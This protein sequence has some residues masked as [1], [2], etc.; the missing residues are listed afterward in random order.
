MYKGLRKNADKPDIQAFLWGRLA[1]F[2]VAE[3]VDLAGAV[4][5][6]SGQGFAI[7]QREKVAVENR[8]MAA[9]RIHY[10]GEGWQEDESQR[11]AYRYNPFDLVLNRNGEVRHVEVKGTRQKL[12]GIAKPEITVFLTANEVEH[13]RHCQAPVPC[14]SAELFILTDV[15]I[16]RD[17]AGEPIGAG[18]EPH[19]RDLSNLNERHLK[20]IAFRYTA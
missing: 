8:A 10:E 3:A 4:V 20:A 12:K 14:Q 11:D 17:D 18:G 6:R 13:A 9:A 1:E 16:I 15:Q 19:V 7:D 5:S 2:G